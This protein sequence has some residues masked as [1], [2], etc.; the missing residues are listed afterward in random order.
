MRGSVAIGYLSGLGLIWLAGCAGSQPPMLSS[1]AFEPVGPVV[2]S[3][4]PMAQSAPRLPATQPVAVAT[5]VILPS[6]A[7]QPTTAPSALRSGE[8][9]TLGGV[10]ADVNGTP[11]YAD[12]L[13]HL[14]EKM[15]STKAAQMSAEEFRDF[16][17]SNL[18]QAL[19]ELIR[20]EEEYATAVL[21][22][23]ED[24]K[25]LVE[26]IL[27]RL[28]TQ[29]IIEAGGSL[30][31]AKRKAIADGT[32]FDDMMHQEMRRITW[33]LYQERMVMPRVQV[34]AGDMRKYYKANL[35]RLYTERDQAEYRIIKIDPAR[36]GGNDASASAMKRI[37]SIRQ[38]AVSGEDFATLASTENQDD[39]LKKNA[40]DPGGWMQR[41]VYRVDAVDHAVWK[42][43][44]GQISQVISAEDAF[45][46]VKVEAMKAGR[47][48]PFDD[49]SVQQEIQTVLTT[50]QFNLLKQQMIN[51]DGPLYRVDEAG[52]EA[53][54]DMAMQ[55]YPR[56]S[57]KMGSE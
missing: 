33:E 49:P 39:Y 10:V 50:Q 21:H 25:K 27:M 57:K 9:N 11:I 3:E 17:A 35:D 16:A 12:T 30:E 46:I 4:S 44:P 29:K 53:A 23:S 5:L 15:L 38:R 8:Y 31:L 18:S 56:W 51:D 42:L 36:I 41:D 43:Q 32:N 2:H 47:I 37:N 19:G 7:T 45:Y 1:S 20:S 24:D 14:Q 52:M 55:E 22:L 54:I 26:A 40:G 48:R 6:P 34:T 28:R 13:L